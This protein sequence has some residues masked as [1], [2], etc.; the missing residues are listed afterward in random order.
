MKH[1]FLDHHRE[2]NSLVHLFDPRLKI[3]MMLLFILMVVTISYE[4]RHWLL[5]FLAVPLLLAGLSRISI[6]HFL[7]KL[8]KLYPM[9]LFITVFIPFFP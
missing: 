1:E 7:S 5:I 9:I 8:F 3:M 6:M 4:K 2:G